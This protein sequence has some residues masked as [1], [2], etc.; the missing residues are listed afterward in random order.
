MNKM[1]WSIIT[2]PSEAMIQSPFIDDHVAFG[3]ITF[4]SK[5]A[6]TNP[7]RQPPRGCLKCHSFNL[8]LQI[9]IEGN[10]TLIVFL[11]NITRKC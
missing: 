10:V 6:L 3:V 5:Q 9:N 2:F 4:C 8:Q 1:E 7:N 11:I